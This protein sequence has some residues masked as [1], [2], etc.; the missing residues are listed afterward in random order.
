MTSAI[1]GLTAELIA[2]RPFGMVGVAVA[3]ALAQILQN[4]L[5]LVI[6]HRRTGIWSHAELSLRPIRAVLG[7]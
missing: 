2:V 7:R 4:T 5:Q 3:T 1:F 6:G